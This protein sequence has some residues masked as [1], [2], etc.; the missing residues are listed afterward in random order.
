[1]DEEALRGPRNQVV[2]EGDEARM[3][4]GQPARLSQHES[5][6]LALVTH[7]DTQERKGGSYDSL[8]SMEE[9]NHGENGTR[10]Q[11]AGFHSLMQQV[12]RIASNARW[13]DTSHRRVTLD[14]DLWVNKRDVLGQVFGTYGRPSRSLAD[15]FPDL[16]VL[17]AEH[18]SWAAVMLSVVGTETHSHRSEPRSLP[19]TGQYDRVARCH[20]LGAGE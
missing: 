3:G 18:F 16:A 15:C 20:N 6:N 12:F 14:T 9:N 8:R 13:R 11:S 19:V 17:H 2:P 1:M 5:E 10:N 4:P 7:S